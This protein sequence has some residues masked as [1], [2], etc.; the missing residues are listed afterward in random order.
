MVVRRNQCWLSVVN[1]SVVACFCWLCGSKMLSHYFLL[2]CDSQYLLKQLVLSLFWGQQSE[3]ESESWVARCIDGGVKAHSHF[4]S[5][6]ALQ[7]TYWSVVQTGADNLLQKILQ[8]LLLLINVFMAYLLVSFKNWRLQRS[9]FRR[10]F[11]NVMTAQ[12]ILSIIQTQIIW[13]T[14][15][16]M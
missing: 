15:G 7:Q 12:S 11:S 9:I 3:S 10:Y 5:I 14:E 1:R 2:W 6:T 8:N 13:T 16:M 4:S